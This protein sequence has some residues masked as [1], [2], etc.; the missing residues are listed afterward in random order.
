MNKKPKTKDTIEVT[1]DPL[2]AEL[3]AIK[4]RLSAIETIQSISNAGAV[5]KYI[6]AEKLTGKGKQILKRMANNLAPGANCEQN[7]NSTAT[8]CCITTQSRFSMLTYSAQSCPKTG[9]FE[10]SKLF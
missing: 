10:W 4:D 6:E 2:K 8:S 3:V 1:S 9:A 7:F 5:K